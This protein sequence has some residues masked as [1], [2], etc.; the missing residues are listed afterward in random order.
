WAAASGF[1]CGMMFS[2]KETCIIAFGAMLAALFLTRISLKKP[3]QKDD[4]PVIPKISHLLVFLGT[5]ALVSLVLYSSFF[6]NPKGILDS[7]L[8]FGT[9]FGRAGDAG[10]HSHPFYYYV[11]MLVFSQYGNGPVWSEALVLLLALVG[12]YAAFQPSPHRESSPFFLRF[13][14]FYTLLSTAVYSLIPY[15]TPWNMLP[16]YIGFILLAGYGASFLLKISK[17]MIFRTAVVLAFVLSLFH[18][19]IQCSY[20]NFKYHADSRNPYV[21][22][23]TSSDFLN[24]VNRINDLSP[25]HP[26]LKQILIKVITPPEEAWPLPWYLRSYGRVG[27]WQEVEEAGTLADVP[28]IISSSD[29]TTQLQ[30]YLE[31]SHLLEYYELRPGILLAL[32]IEQSL[33]EDFFQRKK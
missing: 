33:W 15:K 1:F 28:I 11:K 8:A 27:Y 2:T 22:S 25:H 19:A 13:L 29:K 12:C 7:V 4:V 16:F 32:H 14:A 26:D 17:K 5:G 21:Y 24:L 20:A 3:I 31:E 9:Y 6:Q 23:H 30:S 18:L 10:F